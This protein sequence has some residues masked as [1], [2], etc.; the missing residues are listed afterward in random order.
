[1]SGLSSAD[2]PP[3]AARLQDGR[4]CLRSGHNEAAV[5]LLQE[6]VEAAPGAH[7]A[8]ALLANALEATGRKHRARLLWLEIARDAGAGGDNRHLWRL[9]RN[10]AERGDHAEAERMLSAFLATSPGDLAAA[11]LL[12]EMRLALAETAAARRVVLEQHAAEWPETAFSLALVAAEA[13]RGNSLPAART[14]LQRAESM[15]SSSVPAAL[16][17]AECRESLGEPAE[18]LAMLDRAIAVHP[19][20]AALWRARLRVAQAAGQGKPALLEI[21][22]RLVALEPTRP[23]PHVAQ[24]R[25]LA[26]F[27]DWAGAAEA[28]RRALDLDRGTAEHW[29]GLMVALANLERNAAVEALLEEARAFFRGRGA[30]G[31]VDLATL[32]SVCGWHDRAAALAAGAMANPRTRARA[33]DA[34]AAAL[35]KGGHYLRAWG[36]LGAAVQEGNAPPETLRL[37]ARCA[38]AL[39][40]PAPGGG[41][42][43]FPDTLFERA[44]LHPPPRPVLA[45]TPTFMLVTSSLGAGGAERQVALSAAGVA[46]Q[47]AAAGRG[48]AVLVGQDL[49]PER[50]RAMMRQ[51][52]ET[53]ELIIEDLRPIDEAVLFRRIAAADPA[54]RPALEL[55]AALPAAISRDVIKLYDCFRRHRP[56]LVH[57]WQDGV[58]TSGSVA[59]VLAGVPRIVGSMRNVVAT[60]SDR[61]RYRRYLGTMYRALSQRPDVHFTANSGAGALDYERWLGL[62]HGRIQV[63]R[64]GLELDVV[65]ARAP[66]AAR[67]AARRELGLAPDEL[68]VGGTFRLAPAKRP[69]LWIAVAELVAR[70]VPRS[71]FVIVGDGALRAELEALIAGRGLSGRITLAGRRSPVEPW[72]GAMDVMLLASEVEGLPN[73]LLEAQALGVPVVTTNAG[74][75]A[76]AVLDG[77]TGVLVDTDEAGTLATAV[78]RVLRDEAMRA[79]ARVG[80]PAFIEQ[81]F[82]LGR[83]VADTLAAYGVGHLAKGA[84]A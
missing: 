19:H 61:R 40:L 83:M 15:W 11:E 68:L 10:A 4:A 42:P 12:L 34:A 51:V 23:G 32:E 41:V 81:R 43:E 36:Y 46:R 16:R 18:A 74:G 20:V 9:G 80:A 63:L 6:V 75:S 29:R 55:I 35:L 38:A 13:R 67:Q 77:I 47:L 27:K 76:E 56:E 57:L 21:A 45:A 52:A 82:G 22:A 1:M 25:L 59:A 14:A 72:I 69:H 58:I 17:I 30:D 71:R 7:E 26:Q 84:R 8:K 70:S 53:P 78:A 62:P 50:G 2:A 24:A 79:R 64:N 28:W 44:L 3:W 48:Q 39:R 5:A 31:M 37:A 73:V 49:S 66:A 65:R 54:T 33:R 60:E